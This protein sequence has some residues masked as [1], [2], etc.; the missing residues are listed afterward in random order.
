MAGIHHGK[1]AGGK[2]GARCCAAALGLGLLAGCTQPATRESAAPAGQ[3]AGSATADGRRGVP[4]AAAR[5]VAQPT[6]APAV[7][8]KHNGANPSGKDAELSA[9]DQNALAELIRAKVKAEQERAGAKPAATAPSARAATPAGPANRPVQSAPALAE[10]GSSPGRTAP[11]TSPTP[12]TLPAG[13]SGAAATGTPRMELSPM[14][15]DFKE[16]WQG[17]PAEGEFTVK[18]AGTA[19]LTLDTKS[20]CGCTVATRPKSPLDPGETTSFKISYNTSY[21]STAQKRVTVNTNDPQQ[22]SVV[23]KVTGS[24]KA[25]VAATPSDRVVFKDVDVDSVQSQTV[26]LETKY[27]K[28]INLKLRANQKLGPF[29]VEV[30][31]VEPGKL[32]ELTASTKPPLRPGAN[33]A[34]VLLE[35]G[36]EKPPTISV[37]LNAN[38]PPQVQVL[39]GRLAVPVTATEPT[40]QVLRVQYPATM[41]LQIKE[42][43]VSVPSIKWELLPAEEPAA[44]GKTRSQLVRV[45]LPAYAELPVAGATV[46]IITDSTDRAYQ[47]L[48]VPIVKAPAR[49]PTTA[50]ATRPAAT[51]PA[52]MRATATRPAT[53][54]PATTRPATTRPGLPEQ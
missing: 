30:K 39:P 24:V 8:P 29:E 44:G 35:T 10:R 34:S 9:M 18:N 4:P 23:V 26:R 13:P 16:V 11:T 50:P 48:E 36:L 22:A 3:P 15:F 37:S 38:V 1:S 5:P 6:S 7:A 54:R 40:E 46:Q 51:R 28:P 17:M 32:Y 49:T 20:S 53:S 14:E 27:D 45:T 12:G 2:W 43:K 41:P 31:E 21:P 42:V 52:T 25:L 47:K 19:P 33:S